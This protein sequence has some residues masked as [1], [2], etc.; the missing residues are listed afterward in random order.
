MVE[1]MVVVV[2]V[3]VDSSPAPAA[4]LLFYGVSWDVPVWRVIVGDR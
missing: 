4:V 3:V 1:V 2:V